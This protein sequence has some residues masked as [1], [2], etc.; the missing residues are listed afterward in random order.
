VDNEL[1]FM[2]NMASIGSPHPDYVA[3]MK[4]IAS[5][6]GSQEKMME[7]RS[8][9]MYT[10][11]DVLFRHKASGC[12]VLV[13]D[14]E[15]DDC[16]ILRS[17]MKCCRSGQTS[18][19]WVIRFETHG[20]A[21]LKE[22]IEFLEELTIT[23]LQAEQYV[24]VEAGSDA[25][26]IHQ[27]A[28]KHSARLATWATKHFTLKCYLCKWCVS[29]SWPDALRQTGQGYSQWNFDYGT[30]WFCNWCA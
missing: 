24:L 8:I 6:T 4:R 16:A 1:A 20:I 3:S 17:M 18:W 9:P 25:V 21:D 28:L 29:P 22:N 10:F 12:E 2:E 26:L 30:R 13:I 27:P 19:P 15:G 23:T 5:L 14:A 7:T 11:G